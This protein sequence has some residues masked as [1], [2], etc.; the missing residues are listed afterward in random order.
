[1][2]LIDDHPRLTAE[3]NQERR[4]SI[5]SNGG[6]TAGSLA[7]AGS[8]LYFGLDM[9]SQFAQSAGQIAQSAPSDSVI[10]LTMTFSAAAI[11]TGLAGAK[12]YYSRT[13]DRIEGIGIQKIMPA[14]SSNPATSQARIQTQRLIYPR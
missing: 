2:A 9:F 10:T 14:P 6:K 3:Q 1:M 13:V 5:V 8:G 4:K 11:A 7:L 12:R